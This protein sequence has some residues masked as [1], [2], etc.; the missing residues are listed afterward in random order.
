MST[1]RVTQLVPIVEAAH[2]RFEDG[3]PRWRDLDI[4]EWLGLTDIHS[5]RTTIQANREELERHGEVSERQSETST[6]GGR[7]ATEY[8]LTFAQAMV[9]CSQ[10]RTKRAR[11]VRT[12]MIQVFDKIVN[13]GLATLP[14][15]DLR[16]EVRALEVAADRIVAPIL[17]EQREFHS[18]VLGRMDRH[19]G[20]LARVEHEIV[21]IR[22]HGVSR[23]HDFAPDV[24]KRYIATVE[25]HYNG[26]CPCCREVPVTSEGSLLP[27]AE[28]DHWHHRSTNRSDKGWIVC[29]QCN[30]KLFSDPDFKD[31]KWAAFGA[32]H[33]A[34]NAY[35]KRVLKQ[36]RLDF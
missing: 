7:P 31:S 8:W 29:A 36:G 9:I 34:L 30:Q 23:R 22:R 33:D 5:I 13:G 16:A 19:E 2:R 10:S 3:I 15:S 12:V 26:L 4:A 14:G 11:D 35:D 24:R 32:F 21:D 20:R 28:F 6:T 18:Q 27:G 1:L 17:K 25:H